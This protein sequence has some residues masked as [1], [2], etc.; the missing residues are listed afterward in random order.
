[1]DQKMQKHIWYYTIFVIVELFGLAMLYFL[2]TDKFM[3]FIIISFMAT[4]Y[5][6][7]SILHHYHHHNVTAK[8][9][10]EYVLIGL[11]GVVISFLIF[12]QY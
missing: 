11:L 10:I 4:F 3:Q 12:Q 1:M 8:I 5:I 6:G 7:W 2:S 9:V